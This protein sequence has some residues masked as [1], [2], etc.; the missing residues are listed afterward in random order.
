MNISFFGLQSKK[1]R[2]IMIRII[3]FFFEHPNVR[4]RSTNGDP[5]LITHCISAHS[6]FGIPLDGI[7]KTINS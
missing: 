4:F 6:I 5:P 1:H 7:W 2:G 3:V